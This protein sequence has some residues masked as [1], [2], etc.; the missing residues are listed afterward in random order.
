MSTHHVTVTAQGAEQ[1]ITI[2]GKDVTHDLQ[3]ADIELRPGRPARMTIEVDLIDVTRLCDPE[4]VVVL[5][6]GHDAL[7]ALGWTP[8]AGASSNTA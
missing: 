7:V 3:S 5:G 2:D 6:R 8:P 4:T 1:R